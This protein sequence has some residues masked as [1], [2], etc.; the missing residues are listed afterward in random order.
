MKPRDGSPPRVTVES[1]LETGL[2]YDQII[3]RRLEGNPFGT[4]AITIPMRDP[5]RWATY[6]AN[7]EVHPSRLYQMKYQLGWQEVT[8]ADLEPGTTPESIGFQVSETG[9]LCRGPR[10]SEV[11]FKQPMSVRKAVEARKAEYNLKGLGSA[12]AVKADL[13]QAAG[14]TFGDE[15]GTFMDRHLEVRGSDQRGTIDKEL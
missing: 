5:G 4:S 6:L 9:A 7:Q 12:A 10:Q 8:A 2:D 13:V 1:R 3:A 11:L 15:A 14:N